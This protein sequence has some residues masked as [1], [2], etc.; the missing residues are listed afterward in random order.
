M[1]ELD[2]AMAALD[3]DR[4]RNEEM[5]VAQKTETARRKQRF[6]TLVEDFLT[7]MHSAGNPG[8]TLEFHGE[9]AWALRY[10]DTDKPMSL[11]LT[12][13]GNIPYSETKAKTSRG[14]GT[15]YFSESGLRPYHDVDVRLRD[16]QLDRLARSMAALLPRPSG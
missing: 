2:D 5:A 4:A 16:E 3:R 9:R 10:Q 14:G 13:R 1:S 12:I 15:K 7:R 11:M 8:T 6:V